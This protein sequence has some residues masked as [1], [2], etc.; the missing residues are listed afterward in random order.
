MTHLVMRLL[1]HFGEAVGT[2]Q[3]SAT[4]IT[5]ECGIVDLQFCLTRECAERV[6]MKMYNF[7]ACLQRNSESPTLPSAVLSPSRVG[8]AA[9]DSSSPK[10]VDVVEVARRFFPNSSVV[11]WLSTF[12]PLRKAVQRYAHDHP[13][14]P[15]GDVT[16]SNGATYHIRRA[17][18]VPQHQ[19]VVLNVERLNPTDADSVF[20]PQS[21]NLFVHGQPKGDAVC[22]AS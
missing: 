9:T 19:S 22:R 20:L 5:G 10:D 2:E 6:A 21:I 1:S 3:L 7:V 15:E 18:T 4:S 17:F 12:E 16:D 8:G 13:D 11:D 14:D